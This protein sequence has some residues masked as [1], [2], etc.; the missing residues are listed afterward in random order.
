[1][2]YWSRVLRFN[3]F[4]WQPHVTNHEVERPEPAIVAMTSFFPSC[5]PSPY[6]ILSAAKDLRRWDAIGRPADSSLRSE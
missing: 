6:V 4:I 3:K 2:Q 5:H 1:M